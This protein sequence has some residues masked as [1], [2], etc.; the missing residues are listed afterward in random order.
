MALDLF[1]A[2]LGFSI[3]DNADWRYG[4]ADPSSAG[5]A[6]PK[7]SIYSK[8]DD[9]TI[10]RKYDTGDTNWYKMLD[11]STSSDEDGYQNTFMGKT[12]TGSETPTY[13]STNVVSSATSLETAIGALDA[14]FGAAV[15]PVTRTYSPTSDQ[16]VNLNIDQLDAAIG[17]DAQHSSTTY[18]TVNASLKTNVSELDAALAAQ[19]YE[20]SED[21]VTAPTDYAMDTVPK[22][23]T[24]MV[25]WLL[26]INSSTTPANMKGYKIVA[27]TDGTNIDHSSYAIQKLGS[28]ISGL[29][30]DVVIDG[31]NIELD[32][33][34]TE[35]I[36]YSLHRSAIS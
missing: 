19:V 7:G 30:I 5:L 16:A 20:K 28:A 26:R 27:M 6:A 25:E 31:A 24:S 35:N 33:T 21:D 18:T 12:S 8:T 1:R 4:T 22:A 3:D 2:D 36:D 13:S 11:T 10:W 9:G 32:V 14:E 23:T 15:T 17:T 34:A 29:A